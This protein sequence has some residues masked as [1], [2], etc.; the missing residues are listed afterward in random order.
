MFAGAAADD[1]DLHGRQPIAWG[2][3][4]CAVGAA[5]GS[6]GGPSALPWRSEEPIG[7]SA[8][9]GREPQAGPRRA[10]GGPLRRERGT[11]LGEEWAVLYPM[12]LPLRAEIR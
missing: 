3:G 4:R 12:G 7:G 10:P 5:A 8:R 1:E 9:F 11:L 6:E 2:G